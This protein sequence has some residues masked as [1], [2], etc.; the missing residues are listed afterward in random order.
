MD[1]M[2]FLKISNQLDLIII[3]ETLNRN[4]RTFLINVS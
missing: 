1:E 2:G 4:I 3:D